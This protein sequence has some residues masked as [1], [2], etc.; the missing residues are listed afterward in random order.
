[1]LGDGS[2]GEH[3]GASLT[4]REVEYFIAHEWAT[5]AEDVLWRR[6]KAGLHMDEAQRRRVLEVIGR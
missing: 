6:S 1:V 5:T 2:L 3:Y 4:Q